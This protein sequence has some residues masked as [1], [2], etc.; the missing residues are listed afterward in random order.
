[1]RG[2]KP[3]IIESLATLSSALYSDIG[4]ALRMQLDNKLNLTGG[5]L[6]GEL[7][8]DYVPTDLLHA[9]NKSYV[10]NLL[11]AS[12]EFLPLAGG[13]LTGPLTLA[14]APA[15]NMEA[16]TKLYVDESRK[17]RV[18]TLYDVSGIV[19]I[20]WA[21]FDEVRI[22]LIGNAAINMTGAVDGQRVMIYVS[23][24]A[25][26]SRTITLGSNV[27]YNDD[28]TGVTLSTGANKSDRIGFVFNQT[29]NKY[30]IVALARGY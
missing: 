28:I 4:S 27:R 5:T 7:L 22:N 19:N 13:S 15:N 30:D 20:N 14:A 10:D 21:D 25:E 23:Q 9:V 3:R 8:L 11:V 16:T 6:N 26:G 2:V 29:L 24:D 1:M 17:P 18:T 12:G